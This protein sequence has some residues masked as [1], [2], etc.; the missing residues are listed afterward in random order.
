MAVRLL[1]VGAVIAGV[2]TTLSGGWLPGGAILFG[3]FTAFLVLLSSQIDD[4]SQSVAKLREWPQCPCKPQIHE[5]R[6]AVHRLVSAS[7]PPGQGD[8]GADTPT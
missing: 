7:K 4:L 6:E 2:A 5:I 8:G 1:F 3:A